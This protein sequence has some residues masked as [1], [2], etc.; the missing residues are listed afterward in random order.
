MKN[1]TSKHNQNKAQTHRDLVNDYRRSEEWER[2]QEMLMEMEL[3]D[4]EDVDFY[5]NDSTSSNVND[6]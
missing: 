5:E 1:L 2:V 6:N 3:D 4:V